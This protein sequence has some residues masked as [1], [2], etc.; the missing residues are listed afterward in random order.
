MPASSARPLGRVNPLSKLA[1]ALVFIVLITALFDARTQ[2]IVLVLTSLSLLVL[3]RVPPLR[4]L[5]VMAPFAMMGFGFWWTSVVFQRQSADYLQSLGRFSL[6][7]NP[8][9]DAG[10]VVF[11][12]AINYGA[13]SYLFVYSTRPA[14]LAIGLMQNLRM[15]P[16]LAYSIFT[17][18]QFMPALRADL[19]QLR[20]ARNLRSVDGR[21]R[22]RDLPAAYAGMLVPLLAGA[23]RRAQRSAISM[24][25]RGLAHPM[26]R[27]YLRQ[28]TFGR[29]DVVFLAVAA[30]LAAAIVVAAVTSP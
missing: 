29:H 17:A 2:A 21:T 10:F 19:R 20:L 13:I 15:P 12:R 5:W 24:E 23:I 3:E 30:V 25:A 16:A 9:F 1:A 7:N 11:L 14:D 8:G 27:S 18:V 6:L 4:L 26:T 28:S 22:W